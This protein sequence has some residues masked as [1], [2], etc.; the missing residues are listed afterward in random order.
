MNA[1]MESVKRELA[2]LLRSPGFLTVL[3]AVDA[4]KAAAVA[5]PGPTVVYE[6]ERM[7]ISDVGY[8]VAEVIGH[9]T[10]YDTADQ[11][12]KSA[13]HEV[14]ITWTQVGDNELVI[15]TQL[16]RLV[17]A[18]RDVLWPQSGPSE[19]VLLASWPLVIVAEQYSALM[20]AQGHPFVK[21][22]MTTLH[23]MTETL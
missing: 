12:T 6:G 5:T 7:A 4:E 15:T 22:A 17:R 14:E 16:Q 1:D 20:P 23:V 8:P 19:L 18:T 3:A 9:Q 21:G 11:Q 10:T 2:M 13:T